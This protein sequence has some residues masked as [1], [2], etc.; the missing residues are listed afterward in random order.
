MILRAWKSSLLRALPW[1][2]SPGS[3][4][5]T[6]LL[7][8]CAEGYVQI[9]QV[10]MEAK[11]DVCAKNDQ[12]GSALHFAASEGHV[13]LC[14]ALLERGVDPS[15]VGVPR[16]GVYHSKIDEYF[17]VSPLASAAMCGYFEILQLFL[18]GG[19]PVD[20]AEGGAALWYACKYTQ[21]AC[22]RALLAAKASPDTR[23][24]GKE[25]GSCVEAACLLAKTKAKHEASLAVLKVLLEEA[26]G[27]L[28]PDVNDTTGAPLVMC[29]SASNDSAAA[30]L[31][32]HGCRVDKVGDFGRTALHAACEKSNKPMVELLLTHRADLEAKDSAGQSPLDVATK[33]RCPAELLQLLSPADAPNSA[34]AG[35]GEAG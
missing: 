17:A 32:T 25:T 14:T 20:N 9:A 29:V 1:S 22:V 23:G 7:S 8:A 24:S 10:L 18:K 5:N 13:S 33:R 30:L 11:A 2:N 35:T 26:P 27:G 15:T 12:G 28:A 16:L 3:F 21:P 34:A 19:L 6:P 4:G 31:L